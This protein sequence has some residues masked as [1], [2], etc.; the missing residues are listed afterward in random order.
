MDA[1]RTAALVPCNHA[2]LCISCAAKVL[3]TPAR[4]CPVCRAT[5]TG[6]RLLAPV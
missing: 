2:L 3:T 6:I 5:A 1:E 4:A